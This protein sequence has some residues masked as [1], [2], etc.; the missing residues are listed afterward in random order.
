[1]Y[2]TKFISANE[3]FSLFGTNSASLATSDAATGSTTLALVQL[4][5]ENTGNI[6]VLGGSYS[7]GLALEQFRLLTGEESL[8]IQTS[9]KVLHSIKL[10]LF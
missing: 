6:G 9:Q 8:F 3:I 2:G 5:F 10:L 1:M 4:R 7:V